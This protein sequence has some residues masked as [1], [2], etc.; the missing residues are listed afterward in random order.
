MLIDAIEGGMIA[1]LHRKDD[2]AALAKTLRAR[3][4]LILDGARKRNER[5]AA[6]SA[7]S[8]VRRRAQYR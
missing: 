3:V 7:G 6:P 4:D 5:V 8:S 1:G 2:E